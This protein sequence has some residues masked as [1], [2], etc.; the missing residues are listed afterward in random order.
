MSEV[1]TKLRHATTWE[2]PAAAW[3]PEPVPRAPAR[4]R[5]R[6]IPVVITLAMVTSAAVFGRAMWDVYME[7]PGRVMV[8][9]EAMS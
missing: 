6:I 1:E 5:L 7:A 4:R 2:E 3:S 8:R 9:C